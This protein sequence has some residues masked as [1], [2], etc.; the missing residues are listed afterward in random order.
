MIVAQ[1]SGAQRG[2]VRNCGFGI[3]L[4]MVSSE[5][6]KSLTTWLMSKVDVSN[7]TLKIFGKSIAI[8]L[9]VPKMLGIPNAAK[10]VILSKYIDPVTEE[11][12]TNK[13][14]G[15]NVVDTMKQMQTKENKDDFIVA[16]MLVILAL[17]R[18]SGTN[19]YVN[20]E[21]LLVLKYGKGI[22]EFNWCDHVAD[23]LIEGDKRNEGM[24]T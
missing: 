10:K 8:K 2:H 9:L 21:Y 20:R 7:G 24:Q 4:M 3:I 1:L 18:A 19:L 5:M 16:F 14:S 23:C 12:F 11:K 6:S 15:Q 17:Y 13:G 22:K